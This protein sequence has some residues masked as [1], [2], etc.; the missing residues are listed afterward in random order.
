MRG[1]GIGLTAMVGML[2]VGCTSK[3]DLDAA[4]AEARRYQD[5]LARVISE[6]DSCRGRLSLLEAAA[7]NASVTKPQ[8]ASGGSTKLVA[9]G[10]AE[11]YPMVGSREVLHAYEENEV[12][13]D[14]RFKGKHVLLVGHVQQIAKTLGH[15]S[16]S[17]GPVSWNRRIN[18]RFDDDSPDPATLRRGQLV[19]L[20]CVGAGTTLMRSP[21]FE[22]CHYVDVSS[23]AERYPALLARNPK[24]PASFSLIGSLKDEV[25]N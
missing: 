18:C 17:V 24:N 10:T 6:R 15:P 14:E 22:H 7:A 8:G 2:F 13:A 9:D 16:A 25:S 23:V 21:A 11:S 4:R 12:A 3:A 5:E 1:F 20:E 19:I